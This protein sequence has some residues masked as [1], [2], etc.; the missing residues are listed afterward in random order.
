MIARELADGAA[1]SQWYEKSYF[2]E[3]FAKDRAKPK[4]P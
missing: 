1:A 3:K 4:G 2:A